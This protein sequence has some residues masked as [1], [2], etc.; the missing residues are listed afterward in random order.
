M[1]TEKEWGGAVG[2]CGEELIEFFNL[3]LLSFPRVR[4]R[5]GETEKDPKCVASSRLLFKIG[6]F[7]GS[8][9]SKPTSDIF[10]TIFFFSVEAFDYLTIITMFIVF[11]SLMAIF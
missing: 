1:K 9:A 8:R 11:F 5:G 10:R 2:G 3:K 7:Q 6:P 4:E